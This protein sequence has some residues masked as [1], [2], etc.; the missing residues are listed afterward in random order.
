MFVAGATGY[1]GREVVRECTSRGLRTVAHVRPDSPRLGEWRSRFESLGAEIDT[2]PWEL[3]ALRAALEELQPA[4][5]Y[6]LIGTTK[7]RGKKGGSGSAVTDT[8]EAVDYGLSVLLLEA[9]VA[10]GSSPRFIY[11][12]AMGAEGRPVNAYMGVRKRVEAAVRGSGLPFMFA[13]PGFISGEDRDELRMGERVGA[14]VFD[15]S[16]SLLAKLGAKQTAA[17]Y[18]SLTGAQ[19]ARGMVELATTHDEPELIA[20]TEQLRG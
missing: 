8:Y 10:C 20:E 9:A 1:T 7:S 13:R 3:P 2:S 14:R 12:S 15:A 19:L 6:A 4:H 18:A 5:V 16:L 11:L 17:R